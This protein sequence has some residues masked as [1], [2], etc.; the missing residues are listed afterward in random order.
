LLAAEQRTLCERIGVEAVPS[1][2]DLKVG[3]SRGVS[4]DAAPIHGLRHP[5]EE[6]TTGWYLWTGDLIDAD[7][8]FEPLHVKHLHERCPEVIPY[9]ALTPG[10]RFLIA[11]GQEDIWHDETLLRV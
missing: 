4:A 10:W 5:P 8:F 7:D 2:G 11:P 9:L 6:G 1:P 3:I